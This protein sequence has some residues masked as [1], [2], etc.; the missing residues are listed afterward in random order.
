VTGRIHRAGEGLEPVAQF[1]PVF[2]FLAVV[3]LAGLL[4]Y[5]FAQD[6]TD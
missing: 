5:A 1:A 3:V 2:L 4:V 6:R